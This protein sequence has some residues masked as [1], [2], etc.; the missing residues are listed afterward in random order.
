MLSYL[1][2]ARSMEQY[3]KYQIA[4]NGIMHTCALTLHVLTHMRNTHTYTQGLHIISMLL[5]PLV[6]G[7]AANHD[8]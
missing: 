7:Y 3:L 1:T 2:V 8:H 5:L 4:H 6:Y